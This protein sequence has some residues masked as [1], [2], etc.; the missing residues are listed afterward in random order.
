MRSLLALLFF[1]FNLNL[2]GQSE[3]KSKSENLL[4]KEVFE[5]KYTEGKYYKYPSSKIRLVGNNKVY[6]DTVKLIEFDESLNENFKL[7]ITS[8]LLD[9]EQINNSIHINICCFHELTSINPDSQ[10][11]RFSFWVFPEKTNNPSTNILNPFEYYIELKNNNAN[12]NTSL[13][14]FIKGAYLSFIIFGT[15]VI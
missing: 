6:I 14:E 8:G 3:N 11:K 7:I 12:S 2:F 4:A 13:K 9:P 5:T 10:T 15:I 1:L